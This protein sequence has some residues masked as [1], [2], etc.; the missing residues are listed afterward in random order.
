[1]QSSQVFEASSWYLGQETSQEQQLGSSGE[2]SRQDCSSS[3]QEEQAMKNL[4][5][6]FDSNY[7]DEFDVE[8]F[9]VMPEVEWEAHKAAVTKLF[10]KKA[11]LPLPEP[12]R[13]YSRRNREV[14]QVEVYFGTNESMIYEDLDSYL[15]S[16]KVT[17]LTDEDHAVLQKLFKPAYGAIKSGMLVMIEPENFDEED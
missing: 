15:S 12:D 8:G 7:A 4:F 17:E 9:I 14:R 1:V 13:Q 16:F 6:Q 3:S 5:I 10:E 2:V 11:S